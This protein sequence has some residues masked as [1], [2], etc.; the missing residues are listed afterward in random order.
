MQKCVNAKGNYTSKVKILSRTNAISNLNYE[1]WQKSNKSSNTA[2]DLA[3]LHCSLVTEFLTSKGISVVPQPPPYHLTSA[4]VTFYFFSKLKNVL[5]G[6]HFGTLENI[7]KSVTDMLKT[8]L[9]F[10]FLL[11][12]SFVGRDSIWDNNWSYNFHQTSPS[13]DFPEP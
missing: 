4:P 2:S 10:L 6:R 3:T 13:W 8:C 5:K 9:P 11:S 12:S 1:V 7:Q